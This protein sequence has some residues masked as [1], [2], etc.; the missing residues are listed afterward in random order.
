LFIP[1]PAQFIS[2]DAVITAALTE[3]PTGGWSVLAVQMPLLPAVATMQQYAASHDQAV[4][5]AKTA[6]EY[7]TEQQTPAKLVVGRAANIE[8]A[9]EVATSAGENT[10]LVALGP[11]SGQ[12]GASKLPLF[13]VSPDRDQLALARCRERHEEASRVKLPMYKQ[14]V[15]NGADRHF[16][17]F[18]S[19]IARRVRGFAERLPEAGKN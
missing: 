7:L 8:L 4:A 19:E 17:G 5:R 11:W 13:D 18:E 10:A 12:I 9:R 16:V 3:L 15:L 14:V 6:L 1:A 2:D